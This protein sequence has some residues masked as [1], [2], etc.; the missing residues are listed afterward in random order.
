VVLFIPVA[1]VSHYKSQ[2]ERKSPLLHIVTGFTCFVV[3]TGMLFKILH[4]PF[5]GT[6]LMISLPLPCLI[7]LPVFLITTSKNK[8]FSIYNTVFVL[9]LLAFN[10]VFATLLA[11]NVSKERIDDSYILSQKYNKLAASLNQLPVLV[12]GTETDRKMVEIINLA[13]SCR[14]KILKAEG[15]SPVTWKENPGNL[16]RP[17]TRAAARQDLI[18]SEGIE[19]GVKLEKA[20][21]EFVKMIESK[22]GYE[23]TAKTAAGI[24]LFND[25]GNPGTTLRERLFRDNT[26]SWTLIDLDALTTNL[27]FLRRGSIALIP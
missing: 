24:L 13:D 23:E 1:L 11:L 22:K 10:S 5:A 20:V 21:N 16:W 26:L 17:D 18:E 2:E 7:F 9:A 3:L 15:I 6:L 27:N 4:W 25:N 19:W 14:Q 12:P 8:N